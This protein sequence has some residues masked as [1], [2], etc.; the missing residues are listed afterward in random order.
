VIIQGIWWGLI[1]GV[2]VQTVALIVITARTNWDN[3]V[4]S[5]TPIHD[6]SPRLAQFLAV[7]MVMWLFTQVEK[8]IQRLRRTAAD[9][10]GMVVAVDDV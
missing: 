1:I 10:G 6:F 8:A 9:E 5:P 2:A 4:S 3:E 7:L